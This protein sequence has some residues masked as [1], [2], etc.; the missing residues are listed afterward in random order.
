MAATFA[1]TVRASDFVCRY[2]GEEFAVI[3]PET[4]VAE[5]V[6]LAGRIRDAVAGRFSGGGL[7]GPAVTITIGV[8]AF[9]AEAGSLEALV[10]LADARLYEGKKAGRD[11][12]VPSAPRPVL[13]RDAPSPD[14]RGA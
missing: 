12:I 14:R 5:G 10:E 11:R 8:A 2:G 3:L 6:A 7:P 13:A 1:A 4:D 9:P